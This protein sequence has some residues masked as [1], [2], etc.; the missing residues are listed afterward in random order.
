M[1]HDMK[2][3]GECGVDAGMLMIGDPC[4]FVGKES[5]VNQRYA[6]KEGDG[7]ADE[8]EKF[9]HDQDII[10]G[11]SMGE[12]DHQ[13]TYAMGHEGLGVVFQTNYG[14]GVYPVYL[15]SENRFAVVVMDG[16]PIE[17]IVK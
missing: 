12:F 13:M 16:T 14:D 6:P 15:D 10:R 8:Y 3:I 2:V 4:Y 7:H 17:K 9:L 11:N 5:N 1:K